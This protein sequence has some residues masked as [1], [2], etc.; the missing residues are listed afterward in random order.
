M[1]L[2]LLGKDLVLWVDLQKIELIWVL[3]PGT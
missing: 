3:F 2:V 1:T